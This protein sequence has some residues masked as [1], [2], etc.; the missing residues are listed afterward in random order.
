[1]RNYWENAAIIADNVRAF[2]Q[3]AVPD[4][5][6]GIRMA[7]AMHGIASLKGVSYPADIVGSFLAKESRVIQKQLSLALY[8]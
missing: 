2:L 3:G 1:M 4:A 7:F 8:G 6:M 5:S